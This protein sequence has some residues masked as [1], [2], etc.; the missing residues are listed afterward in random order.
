[1]GAP[2]DHN[3]IFVP[4]CAN[5]ATDSVNNSMVVSDFRLFIHDSVNY[6]CKDTKKKGIK[7]QELKIMIIF[8]AK[9]R[10]R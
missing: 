1:L 7:N 9:I 5:A 2:L 8:A 10:E 6:G 4:F 3:S